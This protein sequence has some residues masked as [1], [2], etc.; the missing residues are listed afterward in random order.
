MPSANIKFDSVLHVYNMYHLARVGANRFKN[1]IVNI[2][3]VLRLRGII[4]NDIQ[5]LFAVCTGDFIRV[6]CLAKL[7]F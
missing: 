3:T 2:L 4:V 5:H 1:N 7:T 6:R